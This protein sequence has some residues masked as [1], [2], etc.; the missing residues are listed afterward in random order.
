MAM[1]AR[2]KLGQP[3]TGHVHKQSSANPSNGN[4]N[5]VTGNGTVQQGSSV[6]DPRTGAPQVLLE[7]TSTG[8]VAM[9]LLEPD[10]TTTIRG[11]FFEEQHG[12]SGCNG[13][14]LL[15]K[16]PGDEM[17]FNVPIA[18][19]SADVSKLTPKRR[20]LEWQAAGS[21]TPPS[22]AARG[23]AALLKVSVWVLSC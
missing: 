12:P 13:D 14:G 5:S 15:R 21:E 2:F 19:A 23:P 22:S 18:S 7:T 3:P 10:R 9:P 1:A 16:S 20:I 11:A 6:I 8:A 4:G 17:N